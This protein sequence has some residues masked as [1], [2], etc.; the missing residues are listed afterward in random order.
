MPKRKE[1]MKT[2]M[3]VMG[4]MQYID[5]VNGINH[6]IKPTPEG[7]H[8]VYSHLVM[9]EIE[10]HHGSYILTIEGHKGDALISEE[11]AEHIFGSQFDEEFGYISDEYINI[12]VEE[13]DL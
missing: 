1:F 2:A 7:Y 6:M 10:E 5:D 8:P 9:A 12:L 11:D 4:N 13:H 3:S